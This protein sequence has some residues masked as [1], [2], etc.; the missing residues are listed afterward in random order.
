MS[1]YLDLHQPAVNIRL[2]SAADRYKLFAHALCERL[3]SFG[4]QLDVVS[5]IANRLDRRH[6]GGG[7]DGE[8]FGQRVC[9]VGGDHVIDSDRTLIYLYL[10]FSEQRDD[11]VADHAGQNRA[12]KRRSDRFAI[13]QEEY[14]HQAALL[15]EL[16]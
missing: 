8:R 6:G 15:N 4:W 7:T 1:I 3:P 12:A 11:R 9:L 13:D 5:A 2:A 10:H 16:S 14:V